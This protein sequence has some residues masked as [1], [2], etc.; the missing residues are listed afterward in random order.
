MGVGEDKAGKDSSAAVSAR[1][2]GDQFHMPLPL[3]MNIL[4]DLARARLVISTR[5]AAGG[6]VLA[7][8]P[9]HITLSEV[10]TAVEGPVRFTVC[11][12]SDLPILGQESCQVSGGCPIEGPIRRVHARLGEFL[13]RVTLADLL[14]T[15]APGSPGTP[16]TP[17]VEN[18]ESPELPVVLEM[19]G[20]TWNDGS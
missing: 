4:K 18:F 2:I 14:D 11:S 12:A 6:Y 7:V 10:V 15:P 9:R 13:G 1:E 19:Q 5:G 17:A 8:D 20:V 16:G 3:L